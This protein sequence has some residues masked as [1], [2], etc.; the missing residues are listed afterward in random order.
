MRK[1]ADRNIA[2]KI[3]R[4]YLLA[5]TAVALLSVGGQIIMQH[6]LKSQ[7]SDSR[8]INI[9]GRQRMLSQK[10]CKTVLLLGNQSDNSQKRT[11]LT[12]LEEALELWQDSHEGLKSGYLDSIATPVINSDTINSMF[13]QIAPFYEAIITNANAV[14]DYHQQLNLT[15]SPP[16]VTSSLRTIL[17]QERAYLQAMNQIVYQYDAEASRRVYASQQME[18][19]LL[20]CTLGVLLLEGCFVFRPAVNQLQHTIK[21][22]VQSERQTQQVNNELVQVNQSLEETK[23]ALLEATSQKYRQ[24]MNEQKLRSAYL[25]EGQEEERKRVA[26]EIHDGLGQMLTAMKFGIEKM[27]DAVADIPTAQ[28]N[29]ADLRNLVSQTISEARTISFNLMPAVLSD[30]GISSALKL[31][32]SQVAGS[33]GIHVAFKTNWNGKRLDKNVEIGLY[34]VCQEAMHNAVKY[35]GAKEIAVELVGNKKY[36]QL[37]VVDKGRGF[38]YNKLTL[39][40]DMTGPAHGISNM[41]ARVEMMNGQID[42]LA[43]PGKGTHIQVKIPLN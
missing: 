8:V 25:I 5:L 38:D 41:K 35:A 22:L 24:E 31:L 19:I 7:I 21:L 23:E 33:A 1:S 12:D 27:G 37:K 14:K 28:Q 13:E 4:L 36:I 40:P 42:I 10:I 3:T 18:L 39:Q 6:S 16:P 15:S 17:Q 9:A 2:R 20:F 11:Y 34:R 26:R 32:T 30:F 29:L 43:K